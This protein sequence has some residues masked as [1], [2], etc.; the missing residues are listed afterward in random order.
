MLCILLIE[1]LKSVFKWGGRNNLLNFVWILNK[2]S[3]YS[4]DVGEE[5]YDS[6]IFL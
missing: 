6:L 2:K 3:C 1:V 5:D 4:I